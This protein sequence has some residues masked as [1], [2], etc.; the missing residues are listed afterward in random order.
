[1]GLQ[2]RRAVQLWVLWGLAQVLR[3]VLRQGLS[4]VRSEG[5]WQ[6]CLHDKSDESAILFNGNTPPAM[7]ARFRSFTPE[8]RKGSLLIGLLSAIAIFLS[9]TLIENRLLSIAVAIAAIIVVGFVIE[10]GLR[11]RGSRT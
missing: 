9:F 1:V 10:R 2:A 5:V 6:V 8:Q 7:R 4:A 3:Q 11:W